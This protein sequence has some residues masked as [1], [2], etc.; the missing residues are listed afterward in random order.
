M[1]T[2]RYFHTAMLL[3]N[4]K[5]LVVGGRGSED[6]NHYSTTFRSA[7]LNDA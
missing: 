1:H 7:E 4:G 5:V 6:S 3:P 2:A